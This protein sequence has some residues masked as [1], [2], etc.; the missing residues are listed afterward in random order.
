MNLQ[1]VDGPEAAWWF[2]LMQNGKRKRVV[3][4]L[5][6]LVEAV[7]RGDLTAAQ[8]VIVLI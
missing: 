5:R 2:G 3:R 4:A 8:S 7:K 6:I 1:H